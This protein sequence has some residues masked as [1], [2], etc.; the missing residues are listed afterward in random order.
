MRSTSSKQ[1]VSMSSLMISSSSSIAMSFPL[2]SSWTSAGVALAST[3]SSSTFSVSFETL[4]GVSG[5]PGFPLAAL[6]SNKYSSAL[7]PSSFSAYTA[8]PKI[9]EPVSKSIWRNNNRKVVET[10]LINLWPKRC[11]I[12]YDMVQIVTSSKI[13][14]EQNLLKIRKWNMRKQKI[15]KPEKV[16]HW[17]LSSPRSLLRIAFRAHSWDQQPANHLTS[18][19]RSL[20]SFLCFIWFLIYFFQSKYA[21]SFEVTSPSNPLDPISWM[22]IWNL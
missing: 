7:W 11:L 9:R 4:E 10:L 6:I 22:N 20:P 8:E 18:F 15:Y 17:A 5:L 1:S 16:V 13:T 3:G 14:A 2:D 21:K 19:S 12:N